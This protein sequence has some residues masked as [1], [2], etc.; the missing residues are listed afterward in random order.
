[1]KNIFIVL[2]RLNGSIYL[3]IGA[4]LACLLII[5]N[6]R[7]DLVPFFREWNTLI[8]VSYYSVL[9]IEKISMQYFYGRGQTIRK[10]I[11]TSGNHFYV[12]SD[13]YFPIK[14]NSGI[15]DY[16]KAAGYVYLIFRIIGF[17]MMGF[18]IGMAFYTVVIFTLTHPSSG[19][20]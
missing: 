19:T 4:C 5:N 13:L 3:L 17:V 15:N 16:K 10:E 9:V 6:E 11:H 7:R 2:A 20:R 12:Y 8:V 1:M 14:I 18:L